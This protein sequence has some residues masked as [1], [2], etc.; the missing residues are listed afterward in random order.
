MKTIESAA[1]DA[2]D[3]QLERE[4]EEAFRVQQMS[5]EDRGK[6]FEETFFPL[7]EAMAPVL[8]LLPPREHTCRSYRS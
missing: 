6:W 3:R 4:V 2:Y 5:L 1:Q 8:A 7:Q